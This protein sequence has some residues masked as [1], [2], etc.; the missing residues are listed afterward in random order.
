MVSASV[1]LP[2]RLPV[3]KTHIHTHRGTESF[4]T[5]VWI[6]KSLL[7]LSRNDL[8]ILQL[9]VVAADFKKMLARMK[10]PVS[11]HYLACF[12]QLKS[13]NFAPN[14]EAATKHYDKND[15][16]FLD[17]IPILAKLADTK[18]P[19]LEKMAQAAKENLK[20][21]FILYN[22]DTCMEFHGLLC[23]LLE[24]FHKSLIELK[25]IQKSVKKR[26]NSEASQIGESDRAHIQ[27]HLEKVLAL[28]RAL[29]AIVRGSAII[30]HLA[31]IAPFLE[32]KTGKSWPL[33]HES[34]VDVEFQPL[35]PYS[36]DDDTGEILQPWKSFHDWLRLMVHHFDAIHVLDSH[37]RSLD[38]ETSSTT[39]SIKILFPS[40]PD[41]KL[42]PWK[43]LLVNEKYFPKI[44]HSLDQ[45]SAEDLIA[46]LTSPILDQD[47]KTVDHLINDVVDFK[48]NLSSEKAVLDSK[49]I[50]EFTEDLLSLKESASVG[51]KDYIIQ[52]LG[53][54]EGLSTEST[55]QG[56]LS[57]LEII[58][59]ML[60][61]LKGSFSLYKSV[62][63]NTPLSEGR[64]FTGSSHC[65][66][67]AAVLNS[68]SD[69]PDS[70]LSEDLLKE[71][72]VSHISVFGSN[73]FQTLQYRKPETPLG[74][75]NV[76]ARCVLACSPY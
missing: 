75:L 62:Q 41:E 71:F 54:V 47:G 19:N 4:S 21:P 38:T 30:K 65:E 48:E 68:L 36:T 74:C 70:G 15:Q 9:Y 52:I 14:E 28:G 26:K 56:R 2:D 12:H 7:Q 45:P 35:M 69:I 13:R 51:W 53:Q 18:I 57:R 1:R 73:L 46:F 33:A 10:H 55:N 42:L 8:E 27:G 6:L 63:P 29:R 40:L 44:Q 3:I 76:A 60:D 50:Q 61:N 67:L 20:E 37:L 34:D 32:V 11:T 43:D 17:D 31:T 23:E 72:G 64:G 66:V 58:S 5:H 39:I 16:L 59:N 22:K 49:D 25:D 24:R